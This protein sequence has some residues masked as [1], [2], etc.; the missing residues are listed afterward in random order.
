[1]KDGVVQPAVSPCGGCRQVL[2]E[3]EKRYGQPIRILLCGQ[4][5]TIIVESAND[6]LP[7]AFIM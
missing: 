1:L 7:M 4:D 2:L 5:E 3:T 6:L